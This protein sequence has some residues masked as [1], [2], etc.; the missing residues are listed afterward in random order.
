MIE[1]YK[2]T[3]IS[4]G[5]CYVGITKRGH[6]RRWRDHLCAAK[7]GVRG[8]FHAALR[9][10]GEEAF[11]WEVV[12][13]AATED[14]AVAKE[15]AAIRIFGALYPGG[16]NLT[17][18]G[19][20]NNLSHPESRQRLSAS[21]RR[22]YAENGT[23]DNARAVR[24]FYASPEG[25]AERARRSQR[26]K[27]TKADADGIEKRRL[28]MLKHYAENPEARYIRGSSMRGKKHSEETRARMRAAAM[29]RVITEEQRKKTSATLKGRLCRPV[30][31]SAE[32]A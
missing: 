31:R 29:G 14:E 12:G 1:I 26:M 10:H 23:D 16:F 22:H 11:R 5:R 25:M 18:G 20:R 15:I 6:R 24:A 30:N 8:P 28:G 17:T 32:G 9:A 2:I 13:V 3:L 27:G 21:L 19:D 4:D 7:K